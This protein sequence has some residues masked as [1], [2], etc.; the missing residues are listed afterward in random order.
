MLTPKSFVFYTFLLPRVQ[1]TDEIIVQ[2]FLLYLVDV[3]IQQSTCNERGNNF[4]ANSILRFILGFEYIC[5]N[6]FPVLC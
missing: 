2:T 6:T 3:C 4:Q 5:L 1:L